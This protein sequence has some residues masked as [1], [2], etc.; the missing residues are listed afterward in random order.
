M[1]GSGSQGFPAPQQR[2]LHRSQVPGLLGSEGSQWGC[3]DGVWPVV[4]AA[5]GAVEGV[6]ASGPK[7]PV[8]QPVRRGQPWRHSGCGVV[9]AASLHLLPSLGGTRESSMLR[10]GPKSL[11]SEV[12]GNDG[13]SWS[14]TPTPVAQGTI[15]LLSVS[16]DSWLPW[17]PILRSL[18]NPIFWGPFCFQFPLLPT[19]PHPSSLHGI[20]EGSVPPPP[21]REPPFH[22]PSRSMCSWGA[23][24]RHTQDVA[25]RT[26]AWR[27]PELGQ[28]VGLF[29]LSAGQV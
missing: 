2:R 6:A 22:I 27:A 18:S 29:L 14:P 9:G 16:W 28:D 4:S 19:P 26:R 23:G 15:P 1:S 7:P 10:S 17:L 5:S 8:G 21:A 3:L 24:G 12:Q 20:P 11:S 25:T 13:L